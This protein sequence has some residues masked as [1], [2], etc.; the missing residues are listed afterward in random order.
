MKDRMGLAQNP[1]D[2]VVAQV[3]LHL[4]DIFSE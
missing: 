1:L 3:C 4:D 2:G